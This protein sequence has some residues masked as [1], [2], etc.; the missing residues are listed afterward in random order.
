M[1]LYVKQ[2]IFSFGDHFSVYDEAE[3]E[4]YTVKGEVFSWGKKLHLYDRFGTEQA[5]ICQQLFRFHPTYTIE[6]HGT[7]FAEVI[8]HFTLFRQSYSIS[9][10]DWEVEGNYWNHEY[11]IYSGGTPIVSVIKKWF[12]LGDAYEINIAPSVDEIAALATALVIDAC[13]EAQQR[14]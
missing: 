3:N 6:R 11:Q 9:G 7:V 4:R 12:T 2:K 8:K 13:I 1:N 5:F 14:N 10:P